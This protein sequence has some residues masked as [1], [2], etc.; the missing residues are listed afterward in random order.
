MSG[1]DA[2]VDPTDPRLAPALEERMRTG[3]FRGRLTC[4][5][6]DGTLFP[7]EVA[8][9]LFTDRDG[10]VRTTMIIRDVTDRKA[11]EAALHE[12]EERVR[13]ALDAAR[14]GTFDYRVDTGEV[15]RDERLKAIWGLAADED[16]EFAGVLDRVHPDDREQVRQIFKGALAPDSDGIYEADYRI[17][18]PDG[19]VRWTSVR[20]RVHFHD[21][22]GNRTAVRV[23][24]I[25]HDITERKRPRRRSGIRR[26]PRAVERGP[27]AVRVR[28][29][30]RPPGAAPG[31]RLVLASSSSGGT[32]GS[33]ARTRT[34]TSSSS[35]RAASGCRP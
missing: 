31:N 4:L 3:R 18:L 22:D 20:G 19:S 14:F 13:F 6:K 5:R 24:G 12:A 23:V 21:E 8:T 35:S 34:S 26:E 33:S 16:L 29:E 10:A 11:A 2:V 32:R 28:L 1:R 7:G 9:A 25:E 15:V 30:P 27:G 17:I